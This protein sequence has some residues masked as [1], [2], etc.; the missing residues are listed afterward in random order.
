MIGLAVAL[1]GCAGGARGSA[2]RCP[3]GYGAPTLVVQLFFGRSIPALGQVTEKQWNNFVN[4]VVVPNLPN[5]F[6]VFNASGAWMS[7]EGHAT[8]RE[9]TKVL[10]ASLPDASGALAPIKRIRNAYQ[11]LFRQQRVGMNVAEA[12]GDF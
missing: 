1:A 5:G 4:K 12:C 3:A 10:L 2:E 8:I 9:P 7:P 6:T 11:L